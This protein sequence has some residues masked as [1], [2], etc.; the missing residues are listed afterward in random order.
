MAVPS[1]NHRDAWFAPWFKSILEDTKYIFDTQHGTPFIF[2]GTGTGGWES[3]LTNTLSPGD[4]VVTFRF[5][6]FSHLWIDMMQRLGLDVHV[7]DQPW[8]EAADE[9]RLDEVLRADKD[10]KI[11]AVCVVHNETSTGVTSDIPFV[12][13]VMN[14]NNHPALLLV[15]GVSSIGA[16]QFKYVCLLGGGGDPILYGQLPACTLPVTSNTLNQT[17][18]VCGRCIQQVPFSLTHTLFP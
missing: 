12:R 1:A 9:A 4:K 6:V 5:G 14:D 11:K 15:D 3:A 10:K 16:L 7:I 18:C 17:S 2:P 8:G 13:K